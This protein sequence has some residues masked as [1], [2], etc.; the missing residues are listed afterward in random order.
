MVVEGLVSLESF[1]VAESSLQSDGLELGLELKAVIVVVGAWYFLSS[2]ND[3][4]AWSGGIANFALRAAS[5]ILFSTSAIL[6][7][8]ADKANGIQPTDGMALFG[9]IFAGL[10][11]TPAI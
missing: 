10:I 8:T 2:S 9:W 11:R 6:A 5:T 3:A 4:V 7:A 1:L